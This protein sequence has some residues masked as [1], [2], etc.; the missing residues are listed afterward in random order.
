MDSRKACP[1]NNASIII[2]PDKI[3]LTSQIDAPSDNRDE[4]TDGK[5]IDGSA[6]WKGPSN[7]TPFPSSICKTNDPTVVANVIP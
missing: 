7:P 4:G 2:H 1:D 5:G 6:W 3:G